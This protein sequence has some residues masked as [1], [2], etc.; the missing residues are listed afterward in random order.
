MASNT[1]FRL[2]KTNTHQGGHQVPLIIS[3]GD[4]LNDKGSLRNQYQHVTDLLPTIL[5]MLE[6]E[7]PQERNGQ[8]LV[9][10]NGNSF[11]ES[12]NLKEAESTHRLQYYEQEGHRGIY[13]DGLSAVTKVKSLSAHFVLSVGITENGYEIFTESVKGYHKPPYL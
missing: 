13:R 6:V 11:L 3:K 2:Y 5:E 7:I 12:M 8:K 1:P 4:G 10:P 9:P